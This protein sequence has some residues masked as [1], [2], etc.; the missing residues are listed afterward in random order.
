MDTHLNITHLWVV[1][2]CVRTQTVASV[3]TF[4]ARRL[5]QVDGA[6]AATAGVS[7]D[8]DGWE[9]ALLHR[10]KTKQAVRRTASQD[11]VI[12]R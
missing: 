8:E 5:P 2:V 11:R 12:N 3:E 1:C 10:L 6:D 4:A 9:V 7:C